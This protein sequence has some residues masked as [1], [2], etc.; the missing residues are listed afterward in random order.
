[1]LRD[2]PNAEPREVKDLKLGFAGSSRLMVQK[3]GDVRASRSSAGIRSL[4][5]SK[6][7]Y[8]RS[9]ERV[10]GKGGKCWGFQQ[11]KSVATS[12]SE[13]RLSSM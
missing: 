10:P 9:T 5:G 13:S 3:K 4:S 8:R 7:D 6:S 2:E 1:V 12:A 11:K